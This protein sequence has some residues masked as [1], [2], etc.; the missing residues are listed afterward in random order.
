MPNNE[1][2]FGKYGK[3]PHQKTLSEE[4]KETLDEEDFFEDFN[5]GD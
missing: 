5:E 4:R 2:L 3:P 1:V